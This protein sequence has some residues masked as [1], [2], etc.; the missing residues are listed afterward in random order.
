MAKVKLG[1]RK[2]MVPRPVMLVGAD[3]YGKPNFITIGGGGL[4]DGEPPMISLPIRHHQ[5]TLQ[6]IME[7]RAFSINYPSLE[8]VQETDFCGMVSGREADKVASC[9]FKIFYGKLAEAPLIEQCP[10]NMECKLMGML[11]LGSH[12]MVIGEVTECH[13]NQDCMVDGKPDAKKINA[14]VFDA[15]QGLYLAFGDVVAKA[16]SAGKQITGKKP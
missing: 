1:P 12:M 14:M 5:Y 9:G 2:L 8:Q 16:R 11:N 3:V 10:V 7:N 13:V 15:E 4:A 6:G